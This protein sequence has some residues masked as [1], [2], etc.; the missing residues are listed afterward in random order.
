[1]TARMRFLPMAFARS[2]ALLR[3]GEKHRRVE[4]LNT[5]GETRMAGQDAATEMAP[6]TVIVPRSRDIGG[7]EVRR[8]LPSAQ[9]RMVG[10]FVFFDH[11][12]PA[13]FAPGKG[14]DVRPH[15]HIGLATITYLFE[16]E[17][18]HRDSLGTVQPIRPGDVNWMTAGSGIAHSERTGPELRAAGSR[19]AGIQSWI[20]L[21]KRH[22]ETAPGFVHFP[23]AQLPAIEADGVALRLIVGAAFGLKAPVA[24]FSDMFY[25]DAML[26]AGARLVLPA[27][28]EERAIYV[29]DGAIGIAGQSFGEGQL[30][31]FRPGDAIDL[32]AEAASR[33]ML[34]GGAPMDG[35]RHIWWN[36]VSSSRER[37]EQAKADWKAGRFAAVPEETEFIP[38][39]EEPPP[40]VRYP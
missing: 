16:G 20:A 22:E 27:E 26:A 2:Y 24:V 5:K 13:L 29:A 6:E 30:L 21:P 35:P 8:A 23:K 38:L 33:V 40:P 28:Y 25:A 32:R 39:P 18:L 10:P 34:L 15:P 17:I 14:I 19:L 4:R 7:F 11:M 3:A 36:F 1:M 12:G 9:R 37:I 31:V